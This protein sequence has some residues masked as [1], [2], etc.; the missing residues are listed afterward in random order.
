[1]R[2]RENDVIMTDRKEEKSKQF[3]DKIQTSRGELVYLVR[4]ED[5]GRKVW[6]Y[7]FVDKAKQALF[8]QMIKSESID[9]AQYGK[10]LYSG[11][12]ENPPP[13]I[14]EAIKKQYS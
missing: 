3:T 7:V 6:H 5:S 1:M 9:V 10:V 11:W 8:K 2:D 12:G 13:E 4:G 14:A